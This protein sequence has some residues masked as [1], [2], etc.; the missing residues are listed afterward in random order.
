SIALKINL[1]DNGRQE[2]YKKAEELY[3]AGVDFY[4]R[5]NIA[6]SIEYCEKALE[7]DPTFTPAQE[8]IDVARRAR[9]LQTRMEDLQRID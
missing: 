9:D 3:L 4:A 8:T 2:K 5:G 6:Q 1:G 7:I